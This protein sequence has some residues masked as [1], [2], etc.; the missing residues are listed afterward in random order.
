MAAELFFGSCVPAFLVLAGHDFDIV[1][2]GEN[3]CFAR[4]FVVL[5]NH[6]QIRTLGEALRDVRIEFAIETGGIRTRIFPDFGEEQCVDPVRF[7]QLA[8]LPASGTSLSSSF[9]NGTD[10]RLR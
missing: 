7:G 2:A 1:P 6:H 3:E 8:Q 9:E 10:L 5:R 4:R